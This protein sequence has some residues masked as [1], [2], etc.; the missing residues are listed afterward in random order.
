MADGYRK[1]LTEHKNITSEYQKKIR[2][3]LEERCLV[4]PDSEVMAVRTIALGTEL[5]LPSHVDTVTFN[6]RLAGGA[7]AASVGTAV[8]AKVVGKSFFQVAAQAVSKGAVAKAAGAATGAVVGG[9]LGS[10]FPVIGTA[11]GG[12]FGGLIGGVLIDKALLSLEEA[13]NRAEFKT[14]L[15][16]AIRQSKKEFK[17]GLFK[18]L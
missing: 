14:N 7:L 2:G 10:F 3:L 8:T 5:D 13:V 12:F 6:N 18:P 1:A 9:G 11:I 17:D 16:A 4:R 15:L